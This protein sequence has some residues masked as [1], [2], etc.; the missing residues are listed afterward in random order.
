M[1][2]EKFLVAKES[3]FKERAIQD[4]WSFSDEQIEHTHD[5]IQLLFPLNEQSSAV[6]HGSLL[7]YSKQY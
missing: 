5:Y 7:K 2:F 4:I 1:N 6:F 3:D